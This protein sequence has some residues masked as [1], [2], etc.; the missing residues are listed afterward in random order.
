M[1]NIAVTR[2]MRPAGK[3]AHDNKIVLVVLV[4][5]FSAT[6]PAEFFIFSHENR[7]D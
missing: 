4:F 1:G 6:S 5:S 2:G 3:D 7:G